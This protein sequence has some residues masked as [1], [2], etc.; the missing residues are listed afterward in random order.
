MTALTVGFGAETADAVPANHKDK[1]T[2]KRVI[3]G[4]SLIMELYRG[5]PIFPENSRYDIV[6]LPL[7]QAFRTKMAEL[8]DSRMP[9]LAG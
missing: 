4:K 6:A 5:A 1:V 7:L 3:F 9:A 2:R 8:R